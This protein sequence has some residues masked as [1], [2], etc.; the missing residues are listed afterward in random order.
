CGAGGLC[1][2]TPG[3]ITSKLLRWVVNH[4]EGIPDPAACP[5]GLKLVAT[6]T[7]AGGRSEFGNADIGPLSAQTTLPNCVVFCGD[8][9]VDEAFETCDTGATAHVPN[10][11]GCPTEGTSCQCPTCVGNSSLDSNTCRAPGTTDQ[12]TM[13]GDGVIQL[14]SSETC[15]G[16]AFS[17]VCH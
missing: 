16:S 5:V 3:P 7:Y 13:C 6:A 17:G 11:S 4:A 15:D 12:C 1:G 8:G 14:T 2:S 10:N 9:V